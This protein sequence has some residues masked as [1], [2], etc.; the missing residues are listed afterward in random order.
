MCANKT[1]LH[2]SE[3]SATMHTDPASQDVQMRV[4]TRLFLLPIPFG[5]AD[6][7]QCRCRNS[8]PTAVEDFWQDSVI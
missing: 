6:G 7:W 8:R 3:N 5:A 4:R 2:Q 1:T